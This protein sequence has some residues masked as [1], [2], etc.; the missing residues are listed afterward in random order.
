DAPPGG[1]PAGPGDEELGVPAHRVLDALDEN[2]LISLTQEMVRRPSYPGSQGEG[3]LACYLAERVRGLGM[4]PLLETVD[5][6]RYNL[7][8]RQ[9]GRGGGRSLLFDGH[10]DTNPEVLGWT[11]EPFGGTL[12]NGRI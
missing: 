10:L 8:I 12:K 7:V 4:E 9:P 2:L 5:E 3:D 1:L 11:E 6:G